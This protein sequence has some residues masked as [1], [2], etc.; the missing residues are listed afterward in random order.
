MR[1]RQFGT[2]TFILASDHNTA[3]T[4]T[5]LNIKEVVADAGLYG[6]ISGGAITPHPSDPYRIVVGILVARTSTGERITITSS[7]NV[8]I[9]PSYDPG[10]GNEV[11]LTSYVK[12]AYT[13]AEPDV[14]GEDVAY[15]K[16]Y[17]NSYSFHTIQGVVAA[18]GYAARPAIPVDAVL[19]CDILY[20]KDLWDTGLIQQS[21]IDTTRR[22]EG[23]LDEYVRKDGDS[24]T[25]PLT[26]HD[27]VSAE[28]LVIEWATSTGYSIND[29]VSYGLALYKCISA[30]TS[31]SFSADAA[32]W[33]SASG[34]GGA[35]TFTVSSTGT[36]TVTLTTFTPAAQT[37]ILVTICGVIQHQDAFTLSGANIIF[38]E[39]LI[40]GN[41]VQVLRLR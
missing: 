13:L 1:K 9:L 10:F 30:H 28:S 27:T 20:D 6:I 17:Q 16:D 2:K 31:S 39:T 22:E 7:E 36:T 5:E 29:I 4:Y 11:W 23:G 40:I 8:T 25:G 24:M 14:D 41:T 26:V 12:Y 35:E 34:L 18:S 37:D 21:D 38:T 19:L 15:Y 32:R 3:E 33:S